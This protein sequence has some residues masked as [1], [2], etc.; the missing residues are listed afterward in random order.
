MQR[1]RQT[2]KQIKQKSRNIE[3]RIAK[4]QSIIEKQPKKQQK[5]QFGRQANRELEKRGG[6]KEN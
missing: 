3:I 5:K 6:R 1:E 2:G 4:K